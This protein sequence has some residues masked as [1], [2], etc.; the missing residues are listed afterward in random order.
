[1]IKV[2][3]SFFWLFLVFCFS[4]CTIDE[5]RPNK[6]Q[7]IV[8]ASDCLESKDVTLFH[9]F[10]KFS[11]I[12]VKIRHFS[13]DSLKQLLVHEGVD[14]EIDAVILASTYSMYQLDNSNLLHK[15][16]KEKFPKQ[17]EKNYR[18]KKSTWAGIGI[19]PYVIAISK[20]SSKKIAEYKDLLEKSNTFYSLHTADFWNPFYASI[21]QRMGTKNKRNS[22]DWLKKMRDNSKEYRSLNDTIASHSIFFSSYS[23]LNLKK[24][25]KLKLIF[26]N[27][28][29]GGSYYNMVCFGIVN[30]ARNY[31]NAVTFFGYLLNESFNKRLNYHWKKFPVLSTKKSFFAYQNSAFKKSETSPVFLD[32]HYKSTKNIIKKSY[33]FMI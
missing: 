20:D 25:K 24:D 1:M 15:I 16:K 30:Q 17:L 3:P 5:A 21:A 26:P 23:V 22:A 10:E 4:A 29:T 7:V 8:I 28:L 31:E 11:G 14:T 18:S 6:K 33:R 2:F 9:S 19:D 27:Q 13:P 12:K 32:Y